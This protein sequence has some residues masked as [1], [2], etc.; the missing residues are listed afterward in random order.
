[1]I[2]CYAITQL[3]W[4]ITQLIWTITLLIWTIYLGFQKYPKFT[5]FSMISIRCAQKLDSKRS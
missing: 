3:I 5:T 2:L 1:M 4:T